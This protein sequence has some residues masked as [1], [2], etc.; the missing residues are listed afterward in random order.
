MKLEQYL[1]QKPKY[2]VFC[3]THTPRTPTP[4]FRAA[5]HVHQTESRSGLHHPYPGY[6]LPVML[7]AEQ[8]SRL[9]SC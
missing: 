6:L 4:A 2:I 5:V 8:S 3:D 9:T 1:L 7:A